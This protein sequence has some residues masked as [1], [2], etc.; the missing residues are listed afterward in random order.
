MPPP[1]SDV[2]QQ[3]GQCHRNHSVTCHWLSVQTS[4][5]CA[6][7]QENEAPLRPW[8]GDGVKWAKSAIL[9]HLADWNAQIYGKH[10]MRF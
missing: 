5:I 6:T 4:V 2:P 7:S 8:V 3:T 10:G 1:F 9:A